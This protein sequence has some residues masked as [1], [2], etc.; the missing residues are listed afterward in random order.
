LQ[1]QKSARRTIWLFF[2]LIV[3]GLLAAM[4]LTSAGIAAPV[5]SIEPQC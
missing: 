2:W 4:A 1:A 5:M 3:V